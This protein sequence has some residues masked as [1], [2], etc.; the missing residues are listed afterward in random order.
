MEHFIRFHR[1]RAG[2]LGDPAGLDNDENNA[3][4]THLS[5]DHRVSA[6]TQKQALSAVLFL[7][8][9]VPN[10]ELQV[11]AVRTKKPERSHD[12]QPELGRSKQTN[13]MKRSPP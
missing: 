4:L 10:K 12:E 8:C 6:G 7:F 11:N 2:R 5:V 13:R 9:E 3:F 1:D